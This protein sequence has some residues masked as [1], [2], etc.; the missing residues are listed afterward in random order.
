[1]IYNIQE[2]GTAP[3]ASARENKAAIQR[4]IDAAHQAGGGIVFVPAG[5]FST[6]TLWLKSHV[7]LHIGAGAILQGSTDYNDYDFT[8]VA[9]PWS[10]MP[11]IQHPT[12][13]NIVG[14]IVAENA[15]EIAVEGRGI[16]DGMGQNHIYFP[17]AQ[18][19]SQR[20]PMLIFFDSCT[21]IRVEGIYMRNP[22]Q[23]AFLVARS[24]QV[25][26]RGV[27]IDSWETEN[28]DGLDFNGS[29]DVTISDCIIRAGDDA[30]S[31]K[32]T[33]PDYPCRSYTITNCV[34][35]T[36]WA[37]FR[38]GTESSGDMKDIVISNC[39]FQNCGD[40][41]KIQDC[42]TGNYENIRVSNIVM[43]DVHR[44]IFMTINAYRLSAMDASYRPALG[45]IRDVWIDGVTAYMPSHGADYQ[46]NEMVISGT[47]QVKIQ[48]LH[49]SNS[50]FVFNGDPD[51]EALNRI[52][53]PEY[54]DYTFLYADVFSINGNLPASGIFMRH[55]DGMRITNCSM[56]RQD[57]DPRPMLFAG[58]VHAAFLQQ[59]DMRCAGE[60][61]FH[62]D[63]DIRLRDCSKNG[64]ELIA[65]EATDAH[66]LDRFH[67]FRALSQETDRMLD[68][69]ARS[70]DKAERMG[71]YALI[72][73]CAWVKQENS[74]LL[75]TELA[76][77]AM[78]RIVSYGDM[79]VFVNDQLAGACRMHAAYR[80]MIVWAVDAGKYARAGQNIIE[81]RFDDINDRGGADTRL[82]F[83][84]F[85]PFHT[86]LCTPM[87]IYSKTI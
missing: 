61:F 59:V 38:M 43:R 60:A 75:Q 4:A 33:Y 14:L 20:R 35:E 16:I 81:L 65:P 53:I 80:N 21:D 73:D 1:M 58:D 78:L 36:I 64:I 28:G 31:L 39:V 62:A 27:R 12:I 47:E 63:S 72:D 2:F 29:S 67:A 51:P 50:H 26:I 10:I 13:S 25:Q 56:I 83:G 48:N 7:T 54:L 19:P 74:W 40:G 18:D 66:L 77:D 22:A 23:F 5:V 17:A 68:E 6:G 76:P 82:P 41:L 44:P 69:M 70:A 49:I 85:R 34:I 45:G 9:C 24:R 30:I 52:E 8:S 42:A 84:E 46:R 79:Q 11:G 86:G 87:R 3:N 55:I 15:T 71:N 32:T 57:A 37:A